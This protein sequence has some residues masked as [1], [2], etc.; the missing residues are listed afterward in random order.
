MFFNRKTKNRHTGYENFRLRRYSVC[1]VVFFRYILHFHRVS[2]Q[3][4]WRFY[5][6][7]KQY[8]WEFGS[9]IET[10]HKNNTWSHS[11][12][13]AAICW[14]DFIFELVSVA[15]RHHLSQASRAPNRFKIGERTHPGGG[16]AVPK[17]RRDSTTWSRRN[18]FRFPRASSVSFRGQAVDDWFKWKTLTNSKSSQ[19][20]IRS[21]TRF[22]LGV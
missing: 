18:V 21:I 14:F 5:S 22:L 20:T 3:Y 7:L 13:F 17:D 12:W 9:C 11:L 2:K 4:I 1:M 16:Q 6:V 8:I 15:I 19:I 10:I